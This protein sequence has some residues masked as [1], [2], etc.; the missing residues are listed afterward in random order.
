[1]KSLELADQKAFS[2][3]LFGAGEN[4]TLNHFITSEVLYHWATAANE[5]ANKAYNK[6]YLLIN[7]AFSFSNCCVI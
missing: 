2:L 6:I 4:R 7:A 1:M 3:L 5:V